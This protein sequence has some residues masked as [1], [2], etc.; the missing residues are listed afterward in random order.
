M[1]HIAPL[2]ILFV[3]AGCSS[4]PEQP[5]G[6]AIYF[7]LKGYFENEAAKYQR[8]KPNVRKEVSING[9]LEKKNVKISDWSKEFAG[10]TDADINK[11]SWNGSFKTST[12]AGVQVFSSTDEKMP[13][14]EVRIERKDQQIKKI[15]VIVASHN[16]IYNS[17]DTLRYYP[18]SLYDIRKAQK[19]KLLKSK[20][21]SVKGYL[22]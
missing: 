13:V 15:E 19:I 5:A 16:L 6:S 17:R 20:R 4:K 2:L 9:S 18:D 3:L 8:L 1:R 10:F 11:T 22:K 21:Y 12:S 14:K 7:D